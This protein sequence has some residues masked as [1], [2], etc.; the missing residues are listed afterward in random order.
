MIGFIS[1]LFGFI[2]GVIVKGTLYVKQ[3]GGN[4]GFTQQI[5]DWD[6][7]EEIAGSGVDQDGVVNAVTAP[8]PI[9]DSPPRYAL[10]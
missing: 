4:W 7:V 1:I 2:F 8:P 10:K 5:T 3:I 9:R 6:K